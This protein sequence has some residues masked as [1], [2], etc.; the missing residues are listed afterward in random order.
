[1]ERLDKL[2]LLGLALFFAGCLFAIAVGWLDREVLAQ[3]GVQSITICSE[4]PDRVFGDL[5][6][7]HGYLNGGWDTR[8][9]DGRCYVYRHN[10]KHVDYQQ[11]A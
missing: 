4:N 9:A 5:R 8:T 3:R 2:L 10:P 6:S 1:M 11:G 7:E